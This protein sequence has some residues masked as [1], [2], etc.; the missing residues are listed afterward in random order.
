[1]KH[2]MER[3]LSIRASGDNRLWLYEEFLQALQKNEQRRQ[4]GP[5]TLGASANT[6]GYSEQGRAILGF[7]FGQG[8][9]TVSLTGGAHAD[10]PVGPNTL[11]RL[12][13]SLS[14]PDGGL[15]SLLAR[16]RFLIIP[17]VN[18]DGDAANADWIRKW[19]D[20]GAF[21]QFAKRELPGRDVEFGY[22]D[23]RV[24]NRAAAGFW[25][26]WSPAD[27][28]FSLHGMSFSEGY[29][30]LIHDNEVMPDR[31]WRARYDLRMRRVGLLPHD[32]DR[33]GEK[34]FRYYGPGFT[35]TPC[36]KAMSEYFRQQGDEKT[37]GL[38]HDSSMEYHLRRNPKA[39]CMVTEIPLFLLE[40][41]GT[42]G[43]PSNYLKW[44]KEWEKLKAESDPKKRVIQLER[45]WRR[46]RVKVVS[47]EKAIDLQLYTITSAMHW[48]AGR[49]KHQ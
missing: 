48:Y 8:D 40:H 37:A 43:K 23:M 33:S 36:G 30:L 25:Q 47:V 6:I 24:E 20:P 29:L 22:P 11:Y 16:F 21:L 15:K 12:V 44:K 7:V 42:P 19:P 28:H 34:G 2:L 13:W 49:K 5:G 3:L 9:L 26:Q 4:H 46:Y 10:E 38:F 1:M 32:H 18:P 14:N 35:S 45:L 17:H 27:I 41:S 39:L 31:S